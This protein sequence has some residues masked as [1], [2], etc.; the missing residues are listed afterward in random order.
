MSVSAARMLLAD[1]IVHPTMINVAA[2][3]DTG[4]WSLRDKLN[5]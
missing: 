1:D 4:W 5:S 3:P 2:Y